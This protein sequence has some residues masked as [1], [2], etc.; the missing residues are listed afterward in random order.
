[1]KQKIHILVVLMAFP[2]LLPGQNGYYV[3][4]S[5]M[6]YGVKLLDWGAVS[7]AMFCRVKTLQGEV[8][9]FSPEEVSEYGFLRGMTYISKTIGSEDKECR[10]LRQGVRKSPALCRRILNHAQNNGTRAVDIASAK[11]YR[12]RGEGHFLTDCVLSSKDGEDQ[13]E[14]FVDE[15]NLSALNESIH[16]HIIDLGLPHGEI[17]DRSECVTIRFG[18]GCS[19]YAERVNTRIGNVYGSL[20]VVIGC[21]FCIIIFCFFLAERKNHN[22]DH[23][24]AENSYHFHS[25]T[26]FA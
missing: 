6:Y 7:N 17:T 23:Y 21:L 16:F 25:V 11:G 1:M 4:D 9:Q 8:L 5:A 18:M 19:F 12:A 22:D 2:F 26:F 24:Q 14:L 10:F 3:K 20:G 15:I 13:Q